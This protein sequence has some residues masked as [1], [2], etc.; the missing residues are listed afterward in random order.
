MN[1]LMHMYTDFCHFLLCHTP[2]LIP[3]LLFLAHIVAYVVSFESEVRTLKSDIIRPHYELFN[4]HYYSCLSLPSLF[5]PITF[6]IM[7]L[8]LSFG[9]EI[10]LAQIVAYVVSFYLQVWT[11]KSNIMWPRYEP[12]NAHGHSFLSLPSF[13][14]TITYSIL[15]LTLRFYWLTL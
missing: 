9:I 12:F 8:A 13:S 1:F 4:V 2:L 5:H 6:S 7:P 14:H 11:L 15:A 10:F 3:S